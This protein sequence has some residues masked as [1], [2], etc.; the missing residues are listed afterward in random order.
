MNRTQSLEDSSSCTSSD[1]DS[2][3]DDNNQQ[4]RQSQLQAYRHFLN[5]H[6]HHQKSFQFLAFY[7]FVQS[8]NSAKRYLLDCFNNGR[9]KPSFTAFKN[10]LERNRYITTKQMCFEYHRDVI[11]N[12]NATDL[13]YTLFK[14][15]HGKVV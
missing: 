13:L 12:R 9:M 6:K 4:H 8:T 14:I 2:D 10:I 11:G 5:V 15:N 3:C 7:E 1:S